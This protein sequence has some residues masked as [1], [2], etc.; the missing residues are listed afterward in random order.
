MKIVPP[1][2]LMEYIA[3]DNNRVVLEKALPRH[4]KAKYKRFC[5]KVDRINKR[6]N[7]INRLKEK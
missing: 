1:I 6:Q 5:K 2:A 4:L 7:C 3:F